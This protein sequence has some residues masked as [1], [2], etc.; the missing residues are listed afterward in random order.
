[1]DNENYQKFLKDIKKITTPDFI[2]R[3]LISASLILV[4]YELMK[5]SV[6]NRAKDFFTSSNFRNQIKDLRKNL[7]K[8]RCKHDLLVYALWYQKNN[9]L[10]VRD[11]KNIIKIWEYRNDVAHELLKYTID[12]DF[13]LDIKKLFQLRDIIEKVDI[14]WWREVE[15]PGNP[16]FDNVDVKDT[17]IKSGQIT[18]LNHLISTAL[19][20][21][22]DMEKDKSN[23]VH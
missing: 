18:I 13:E 20:I 16:A 4:A 14:W 15:I 8:K 17:D 6:V 2:K 21:I 10:S 7:P 3:N 19:E 11:F 1:M 22:P 5:Y 9:V 12:S 23:V